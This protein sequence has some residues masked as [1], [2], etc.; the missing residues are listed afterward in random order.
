MYVNILFISYL[1]S[2]KYDLAIEQLK[3]CLKYNK[4]S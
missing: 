1:Q 3:K 4:V 2:G